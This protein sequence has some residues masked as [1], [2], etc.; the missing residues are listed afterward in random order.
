M[1]GL[2]TTAPATT[3]APPWIAA[4]PG[5]IANCFDAEQR[6]VRHCTDE[7]V[8]RTT[9]YRRPKPP[10]RTW[11]QTERDRDH[12]KKCLCTPDTV[13]WMTSPVGTRT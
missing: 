6:P 1:P 2:L 13:A 12:R 9:P 10:T 7:G 11:V 5:S 3:S 8:P 4:L